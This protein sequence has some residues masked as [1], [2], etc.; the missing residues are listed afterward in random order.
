[1]DEGEGSGY[2]RDRSHPLYRGATTRTSADQFSASST[3]DAFKSHF[4]SGNEV[5]SDVVD[6]AIAFKEAEKHRWV[7]LAQQVSRAMER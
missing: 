1:M 3:E 4:V 2:V 5:K 6:N 7:P